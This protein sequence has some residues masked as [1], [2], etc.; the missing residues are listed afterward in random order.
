ME[1]QGFSLVP[2]EWPYT[3]CRM[4]IL[5]FTRSVDVNVINITVNIKEFV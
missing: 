5:K 4:M 3:V 2:T 1:L